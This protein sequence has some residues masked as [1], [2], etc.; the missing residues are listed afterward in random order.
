[1]L[2]HHQGSM[3]N[4][5]K[6]AS[7]L[8]IAT[9]TVGFYIDWLVGLLLFRRLTPYHANVGKRLVKTPKI[10]IRDSGLLHALLGI[11]D[12]EALTGHPVFGESREDIKATQSF[13]VYAGQEQYPIIE[14]IQ[15]IGLTEIMKRIDKI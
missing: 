10:Y 6:L 14:K 7:N 1:M 15:A 13:V 8:S 12:Y 3:L 2:A 9:K 11:K 5:S 4:A